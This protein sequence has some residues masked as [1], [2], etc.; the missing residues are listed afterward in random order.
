MR[1]ARPRSPTTARFASN[2]DRVV[3]RDALVAGLEAPLGTRTAAAWVELLSARGIPCGVVHDVAEAFAFA[4]TVGL[5]PIVHLER[6]D[7]SAVATVANPLTMSVTPPVYRSAPP[8]LGEHTDALRSA[9][10]AGTS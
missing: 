4:R 9:P 5:D 7:G 1:W 6:T 10:D 8:R 2:A 3:N